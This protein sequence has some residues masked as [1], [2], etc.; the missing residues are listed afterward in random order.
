MDETLVRAPLGDNPQPKKTA[1]SGRA[2]RVAAV[3][4]GALVVVGLG[5]YAAGYFMAGDKLPK[6]ASIGGVAIGGL[7]REAAIAKLT[8]E[9]QAKAEAP[10]LATVN[11]EKLEVDPAEAG[12]SIDYAKGV[13][14]AGAG[15]SFNPRHIWTVLTGGSAQ[16]PIIAVDEERLKATAAEIASDHD[17]KAKDATVA[18]KDGKVVTGKAADSVTLDQ[19]AV[20]DQLQSAYLGPDP[21]AL[22]A[23][24]AEPDITDAE[25]AT[26]VKDLAEP[27]VAGPIT[28]KAGQAGQF[29][30]TPAMIGQA[31]SFAPK[32]GALAM[33]LDQAKL[34]EAAADE[35]KKVEL[36]KPK[37]ATVKIE[38]GKPVIVPAVNGTAISKESLGKSVESVLA[39]TGDARTADVELTG[40]KA[41]FS[42]E[43]AKKLGIKEVTGE[44]TVP[45]PYAE[46]RN[47]NIG[48][49]AEL[50]NG[51]LLKPNEIF[52]YNKVVGER[53][54]ERGFV[55]GGVIQGGRLK[56]EVGGGV[57]QGATTTYNAMFF[58]GLKDIEHQP[59]SLYYERYPAGREATVFWG[60]IDMKFQNDTPYG[61]LVQAIRKKGSPGVPGAMTV[62]MWSTK[63]YDI[64]TAPAKK[65]NF[66]YGITRYDPAPG[67]VE[68]FETP[69]FKA[70]YYRAFLKGGK[71]VKREQFSWTYSH[72]DRI[73]C[74]KDPNKD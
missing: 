22:T 17:Q 18:V 33:S 71:E 66:T 14:A 53:T 8:A 62:R 6:Q 49:A 59:H 15:K 12:L 36:K 11:G 65:S 27:A 74:G 44:F 52:S 25:A 72:G 43:D 38:G 30:V 19:T 24:V 57:S 40:A 46:Y 34:H 31:L 48:R 68:N 9:L 51:T 63:I 67:C 56:E 5:G 70:D 1:K 3:T 4:L 13:D 54:Y 45:F 2:P 50:I 64:K 23:E 35:L 16:D 42:T 39:K 21:V 29:K 55:D 60:S 73:V 20:P 37:D 69:G 61:V 58:A 47:V 26:A 10:I 28:L 41:K 32:D 7:D